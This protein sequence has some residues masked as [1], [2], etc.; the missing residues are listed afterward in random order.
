V[1][2]VEALRYALEQLKRR[3]AVAGW[4]DFADLTCEAC[5]HALQEQQ[6]LTASYRYRRGFPSWN[7]ARWSVLRLVLETAAPDASKTL[8][9][10]V[11]EV[12]RAVAAGSPAAIGAAADRAA[13]VLRELPPRVAAVDWNVDRMRT[14]VLSILGDARVLEDRQSAFQAVL[15]VQ[16]LATQIDYA[17][18]S[19]VPAE[20]LDGVGALATEIFDVTR[21]NAYD[22]SRV[23]QEFKRLT[24]LFG[25]R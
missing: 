20:F 8:A 25:A 23:E 21:S 18:G 1:G 15:S 17:P 19:K 13:A 6:W 10:A 11:D 7:P 2:Q 16:S 22:R 5:H 24:G 9:P 12:S 4:I 3:T 14:L